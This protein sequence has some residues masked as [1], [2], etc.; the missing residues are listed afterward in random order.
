MLG[1]PIIH[2]ETVDSTNRYLKQLVGKGH[3]EGTLVIS[4][5]QT[6]GRGRHNKNWYSPLGNL[7]A[8]LLLT[9]EEDKGGLLC[10]ISLIAGVA[11]A[12]IISD[13]LA[14]LAFK[15]NQ[16]LGLKWPNDIYLNQK[17]CA[18]ILCELESHPRRGFFLVVGLGLNLN[19]ESF[20]P[21]LSS[22][23]SLKKETGAFYDPLSVAKQWCRAFESAYTLW[24]RHG[25]FPFVEKWKKWDLLHGEK[26]TV[27]VSDSRQYSGTAL[28][29]DTIG[30]LLLDC[31]EKV[32]PILSGTIQGGSHEENITSPSYI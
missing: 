13:L 27:Q 4:K 30:N 21:H 32:I 18:G 31:G 2:L 11:A 12:N 28:G 7:Y 1:Q 26:I 9:P 8:S 29:I 3:S 5:C 6:A 16:R 23:T 25:F 14:N 15:E 24:K 19:Q 10:Q 17:K 20:P 22:A